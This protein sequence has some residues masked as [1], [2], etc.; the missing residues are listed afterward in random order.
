MSLLSVLRNE[1]HI[2]AAPIV[3]YR[4]ANIPPWKWAREDKLGYFVV[5]PALLGGGIGGALGAYEG[6]RMSHKDMLPFNV[7]VTMGGM[8]YGS[9]VGAF[10]TGLWPVAAPF[11]LARAYFPEDTL[12]VSSWR[13]FATKKKT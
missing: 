7:F 8:V 1:L 12:P 11:C 9:I 4:A 6:F 3:K 5:V 13:M 2:L 10:V